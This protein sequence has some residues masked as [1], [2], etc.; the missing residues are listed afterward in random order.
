MGS[1]IVCPDCKADAR[2]VSYREKDWQ[3]VC[4]RA[5]LPRAYYHCKA[6]GK[7]HCPFDHD[8]HLQQDQLSTGLRPLVCLAGTLLSFEGGAD[9]LLRRFAGVRLSGSAVRR[10]TEDAGEKLAQRQQ[11][12]GIVTPARPQ[13]W[14]FTVKDHTHTA[15]FLGL[16][17]FSVPI[18]K[19]G[20]GKADHRMIYTAVLYTPDK[21]QNHYLV[22]FDLDGIAAQMREA[23]KKLGLGKA[24]QVI[25]ITDGGNG[26]REA[27][28][29]N[30]WD[31]LTCILDYY[32]A[33]KHLHDYAKGLHAGDAAGAEIWSERAKGILYMQGGTAL[34]KHLR[35]Q[36]VPGDAGTADELRELIG[37]FE[38]NEDRADYP[39]YR[40]HGWDIG[41]GPTESACK[42]VGSR[43]KGSG[44]RWLEEGAA[45]VAPLRALYL[46]ST[47]A[48]DALWNMAG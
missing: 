13:E 19:S 10:A 33:A 34:L 38:E 12:G 46:S 28:R 17:A 40:G 39:S 14:D 2:F 24:N 16:D 26:L 36:P 18:Q 6:C 48:W 22:D 32:H 20:G 42:I 45:W 31:D 11:D 1:S 8:N 4:G 25:A 7:G 30:F 29:R 21:K 15:A 37:Y 44:M 35:G 27:L 9:D 47:E 23:S 5:S 43:L 41:S 3:T